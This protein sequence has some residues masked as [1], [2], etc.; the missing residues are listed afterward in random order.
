VVSQKS[1]LLTFEASIF[2][3]KTGGQ[4]WFSMRR[5]DHFVI[6]SLNPGG[7]NA[8]WKDIQEDDTLCFVCFYHFGIRDDDVDFDMNFT[9]YS[10]D[11]L[12]VF[13]VCDDDHVVML[14]LSNPHLVQQKFILFEIQ[15]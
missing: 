12:Q 6:N 9:A 4:I 7:L 1:I 8:E 3:L 5:K 11:P 2:C 15:A 14:S 10:G 13:V